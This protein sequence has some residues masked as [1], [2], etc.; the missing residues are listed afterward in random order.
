[1]GKL[2]EKY[3]VDGC[4]EFI[5]RLS[6]YCKLNIIELNEYKVKDNP[7][8]SEI[9][10]CIQQEGKAIKEKLKGYIIPLCIEGKQISSEK[11]S[12]LISDVMISGQSTISFVIGGS[13]GISYEIKK[14]ANFS[15]SLSPMTFPHQ[16][17]RLLLLEQIYR[18]CNI[19]SNGK[20]HK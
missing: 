15:L 19:S 16:L 5:K 2:K 14:S 1:M 20:Y 17:A 4:S 8:A 3:L 11:F 6:A 7:S 18:A 9:E 13:F 12:S 10:N